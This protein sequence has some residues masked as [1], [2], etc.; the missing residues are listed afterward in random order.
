LEVRPILVFDQS[1]CP[2]ADG[3]S[4]I[5]SSAAV[6]AAEEA[7]RATEVGS[8]F[9]LFC[10]SRMDAHGMHHSRVVRRPAM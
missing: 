5:T 8:N 9:C 7:G 4:G 2:A 6:D 10:S 1:D 3:S